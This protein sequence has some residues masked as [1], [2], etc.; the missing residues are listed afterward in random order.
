[1]FRKYKSNQAKII[2]IKLQ[3]D[4]IKKTS[5]A[6]TIKGTPPS[7]SKPQG[8]AQHQREQVQKV[9]MGLLA[10]QTGG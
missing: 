3:G 7:I 6:C 1:V 8:D 4:A 2:Q 5:K 10:R 9:T